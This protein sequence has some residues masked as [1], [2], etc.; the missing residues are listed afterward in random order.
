MSEPSSKTSTLSS[1]PPL[2]TDLGKK[3]RKRIKQLKKGKGKLMSEINKSI[4]YVR[5]EL[6]DSVDDNAVVI[7]V[8][9]IVEKKRRKF[10]GL[11]KGL[12][13]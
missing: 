3:K 5:S 12:R 8:V 11:L 10:K 2:I 13:Y 7:P 1:A 4:E 6:R 9:L